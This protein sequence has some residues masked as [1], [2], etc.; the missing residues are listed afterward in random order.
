M[1]RSNVHFTVASPM[2]H[3]SSLYSKRPVYPTSS[4]RPS[5]QAQPN[6][7]NNQERKSD[8][9]ETFAKLAFDRPPYASAR[10]AD[11]SVSAVTV[12]GWFRAYFLADIKH[13]WMEEQ[14][15]FF[16]S[17]RPA[18]AMLG[19]KDIVTVHLPCIYRQAPHPL[20]AR[21]LQSQK[22]LELSSF[23]SKMN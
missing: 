4:K 16:E 21:S 2:F 6:R 3:T 12:D 8:L 20:V 9:P 7:P 11:T 10:F 13:L 23:T 1:S 19:M 14:K 22:G 17:A 5:L 18:F 15:I